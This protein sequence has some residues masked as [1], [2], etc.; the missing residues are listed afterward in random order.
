[1]EIRT[2]ERAKSFWSA[3]YK[4]EITWSTPYVNHHDYDCN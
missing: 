1:M 2:S 4:I 3:K